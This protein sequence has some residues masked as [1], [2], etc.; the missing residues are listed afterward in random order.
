MISGLDH[1]QLAAPRGCEPDARRFYGELLGLREVPKP[2]QLRAT[3]GAWFECGAQE[4]HVG[5][6]DDFTAAHKAHPGLMVDTP[7]NLRAL[8]DRLAQAG[9]EVT[10]NDAIP[11]FNRF[12]VNDPWGNRVELRAP[13]ERP[14]S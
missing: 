10:W 6:T 9:Y 8:G 1:V 13:A 2:E 14:G 12:Y 11:E 3:G 7:D 5:I 4:L